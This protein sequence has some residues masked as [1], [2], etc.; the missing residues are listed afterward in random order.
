VA[1]YSAGLWR[2]HTNSFLVLNIAADLHIAYASQI[3]CNG[4]K[5]ISQTCQR[6]KR[7]LRILR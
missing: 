6:L 7:D 2:I 5:P 1:A 3:D 4:G